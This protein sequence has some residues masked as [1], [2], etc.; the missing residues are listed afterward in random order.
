ML[1]A[2]GSDKARLRDDWNALFK[3]VHSEKLGEVAAEFD[4]IHSVHR[5]LEVGSLHNIVPPALLRPYLIQAVERGMERELRSLSDSPIRH[6]SATNDATPQNSP[7]LV[8]S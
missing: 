1:R 6:D 7:M 5:A 3:V 4:R 2:E 8:G